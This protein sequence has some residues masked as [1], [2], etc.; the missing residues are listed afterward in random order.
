MGTPAPMTRVQEENALLRKDPKHVVELNIEQRVLGLPEKRTQPQRAQGTDVELTPQVPRSAT[1]SIKVTPVALLQ[2]TVRSP[3]DD[4]ITVRSPDDDQITLRS[5]DD[6]QITVRSPDDDQITVR[7]PDDDQISARSPNDD[8]ITITVR[9]PDDDQITVRSP[10][11]DQ[12]TVRSP[13]DDQITLRSPDDDQIT[14]RSPDDDQITV[15]SPDDDQITVRSPDDDQITVRSPDD[16]QITVRSPECKERKT[17]IQ[18]GG[19]KP[20]ETAVRTKLQG[21]KSVGFNLESQVHHMKTPELFPEPELQ[22]GENVTSTSEPQPQGIKTVDQNQDPS[23][24]S[25]KSIQWIPG[26]EF[27]SVKCSGLNHGSQS[28]GVKSTE[29]KTSIQLGGVKPPEMTVEPKPQGKK[30]VDFNLESKVQHV[31][32]PEASP[33][34][35][36]QEGE[37]SEPQS[38]ICT[39]EPSPPCVNSTECNPKAHLQGVN[40]SACTPGQ[41]PQCEHFIVGIIS[42]HFFK[43]QPK[44]SSQPKFIQLLFQGLKQAFQRAHRMM[45]ITGQKPEDGTSPDNLWSSKNLNLKEND[46]DDCLTGDGKG[47]STPFVK[48]RFTGS[49][50]KQE[51]RLQETCDQ[52]QQPKQVSALQT[53]PLELKNVFLMSLSKLLQS[54]SLL[55]IVQNSRAKK[56]YEISSTE[57][58]NCSKVGAKFQAQETLVPDSLLKRTL[59][60]HF[61]HEQEQDGFFRDWAISNRNK[62]SERTYCSLSER[63][64]RRCHS[65]QRK[66]R[67]PS[68]RTLRNLSKRRHRSPSRRTP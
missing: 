38:S 59:Q 53:R 24:G 40:S 39:P 30:S 42:G 54:Y 45:A 27:H 13:N 15:R 2:I 28:E 36:L 10:N 14:V 50:P 20:S 3:D 29:R 32:T 6:D 9:S 21:E 25:V 57:S 1:G 52:A 65:P 55:N 58:K 67:S 46:E 12:I 33:E 11:D 63:P 19:V 22:K 44:K 8:Q 18:L 4:Q 23:A 31:K 66:H 37:N 43:R 61:K 35:E 48:Q 26:P 49:T 7:S 56:N 47:A 5:P 68:D 17:S 16:D 41:N 64:H 34:P 60:S 62:P 51:D